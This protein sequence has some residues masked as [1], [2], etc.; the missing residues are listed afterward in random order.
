[1]QTPLA[2]GERPTLAY[3]HFR[4]VGKTRELVWEFSLRTLD[5]QYKV[6]VTPAGLF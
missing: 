6:A 5:A 2:I 4:A 3:G 1:L